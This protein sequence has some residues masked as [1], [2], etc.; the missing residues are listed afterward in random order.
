MADFE[1]Q[2]DYKAADT[3]TTPRVMIAKF[4]DNY[5]ER[6]ASGINSLPRVWNLTFTNTNSEID[7]IE[8]FLVGKGGVTKFTF[9]PPRSVTD[10]TVVCSDPWKKSEIEYNVSTLTVVFREVFEA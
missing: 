5:E 4:G 1:W 2:P 3:T 9:T 6:R 7:D 10:A 8:D